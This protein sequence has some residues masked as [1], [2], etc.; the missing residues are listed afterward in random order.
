ML[1]VTQVAMIKILSGGNEMLILDNLI[2]NKN[3]EFVISG[4]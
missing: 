2:E 4:F 3:R 1:E